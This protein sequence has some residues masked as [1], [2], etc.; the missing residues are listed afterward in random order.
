MRIVPSLLLAAGLAAAARVPV[1]SEPRSLPLQGHTFYANDAWGDSTL[2]GGHTGGFYRFI[3][4][5]Q[6]YLDDSLN[7]S[8]IQS[9]VPHI[10]PQFNYSVVS[11]GQSNSE[12][13]QID[14]FSRAIGWISSPLNLAGARLPGEVFMEG[15]Y[16]SSPRG[17][18]G[19]DTL[20]FF[21]CGP[22]QVYRVREVFR[23]SPSGDTTLTTGYW[24]PDDSLVIG[25]S[26]GIDA[27]V[28]G[29]AY[30]PDP[31]DI[32]P[33]AHC[34]ID[35]STGVGVMALC[36][37]TG[38]K[39][40]FATGSPWTI[41]EQPLDS[42]PA[43]NVTAVFSGWSTEWLA[44]SDVTHRICRK[45]AGGSVVW[46]SLDAPGPTF[47]HVPPV[48]GD[49]LVVFA[50]DSLR[51]SL[52][53]AKWTKDTFFF[54]GRVDLGA[55]VKYTMAIGGSNLWVQTDSNLISFRVSWQEV[56]PSGIET[57]S[58]VAHDLA[59]TEGP[60]G[61]GFLWNGFAP[62]NATIQGVDGR[63][64]DRIR[65]NPGRTTWWRGSRSGLFLVRTP[66]GTSKFLVR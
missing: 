44:Y 1:L 15:G 42:I 52:I 56:S 20:G 4:S 32:G 62:T 11:S 63:V 27:F 38:A 12:V 59:V 64:V 50:V 34:N 6:V 18:D 21:L 43:P 31:M 45:T 60:M 24:I 3:R 39:T 35:V 47:N 14:P 28:H 13:F 30:I 37:W 51:S 5:G 16:M 49:S 48:R 40:Y 9:S 65:L 53:L 41:L 57:R 36:P 61:T 55:P 58:P 10:Y 25:I 26:S 66:D 17:V 33:D 2:W 29:A 7:S 8:Q 46:D 54:A 19:S 23:T 22:K